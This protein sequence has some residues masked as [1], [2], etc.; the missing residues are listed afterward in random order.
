MANKMA[1]LLI[2][3]TRTPELIIDTD[4]VNELPNYGLLIEFSQAS[5]VI[6]VV[7]VIIF[8]S[9]LFALYL[10]NMP[11]FA[12]LFCSLGVLSYGYYLFKKH[13][14]RR[15]NHAIK[16][17]LFTELDWCYMQFSDQRI[18]RATVDE[19]TILSEH[20]VILNLA[21]YPVPV[22]KKWYDY[23]THYSILITAEEVGSD[24]FRELKRSLRL[25]QFDTN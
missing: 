12:L 10:T 2:V 5:M 18:I 20:L 1:N 19:N 16:R 17:L 11:L 23:F 14:F 6:K 7:Y 21:R 8:M 15:H 24:T 4:A 22:H 9:V 13:L 25:L 3:S